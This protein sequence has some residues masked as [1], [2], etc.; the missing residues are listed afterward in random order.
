MKLTKIN[1]QNLIVLFLFLILI[2]LPWNLNKQEKTNDIGSITSNSIGYFQTNTCKFS[3]TDIM[4]NN[5]TNKDIIILPDKSSSIYCHGKINGVDSTSDKLNVYV[6][7]NLHLDFLVQSSIFLLF[8]FLIPRTKTKIFNFDPFI[9]VF[10]VSLIF[11]LHLI[12]EEKF[13]KF[14]LKEFNL[15]FKLNNY[16]LFAL[17]SILIFITIVLYELTKTRFYNLIN[18]FPFLFLVNG[19]Y[20]SFNFNFFII[21]FCFYGVTALVNKKTNKTINLI[22]IVFLIL[23]YIGSVANN[24]YFDVDKLKGFV[25]S[26][27]SEVSTVYWGLIIYLIINGFLYIFNESLGFINLNLLKSNLIISSGLIVVFGVISSINPFINFY[28]Y[29]FFGLQKLGIRTIS[30]IEG[31]TW[32]GISASAEAIG[33]FFSLSVLFFI[34]G[35]FL[36]GLKIQKKE[37][38]FLFFIMYGIYRANN[39]AAVIAILIVCTILFG[40]LKKFNKKQTIIIF[41]L[42]I[43]TISTILNYINYSYTLNSRYLLKQAFDSSIIMVDLPGDQNSN[44]AI[45][46]FSFGQILTYPKEISNISSSLYFATDI[47]TNTNN[48]KF[49]PNT[50]GLVSAI[51]VPINRSEKWGIFLAKY[52]PGLYNFMFGYG[53]QQLNRYYFDHTTKYNDGLVLPHSSFLDILIF[54]GLIGIILLITYLIII[55]KKY[56]KN[57]FFILL[58]VFELLNLLKSDS[59]LYLSSFIL[60]LFLLNTYKIPYDEKI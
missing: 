2:V 45:D 49:F 59:I 13:Y 5:I 33:E 7:T 38:P 57:I 23:Q 16:F 25:S 35:Y 40:Y 51:S 27:Q 52:N 50:I 15:S 37:L 56:K 21:F 42:F 44:N 55:V 1:K 48:F 58:L 14:F 29:Y 26:T 11:Y 34:L 43:T 32:R 41:L 17:I 46:N 6:G 19:S 24:S 8:L 10:I 12:S 60:F 22:F 53:F 36:R 4:N 47:Y 30:S 54:S 31:N 9:S 18:Y 39:V 20:N 3:L 28:T